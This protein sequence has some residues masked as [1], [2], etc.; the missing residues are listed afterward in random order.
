MYTLDNN[1]L[2]V[3]Y[4]HLINPKQIEFYNERKNSPYKTFSSENID[5]PKNVLYF[6]IL[7]SEKNI[8]FIEKELKLIPGLQ[9]VKYKDIYQDDCYNLEIYDI[10]SSKA[11]AIEYLKNKFNFDKLISFGDNLNDIPMFNISDECYAVSNAVDELKN[12]STEIIGSNIDDSVAKYIYS[13][14]KKD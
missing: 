2:Y 4:K 8:N 5:N 9:I 3:Y 11:N 13:K 10:K 12:I 7:D 6:T 14:I 1:H